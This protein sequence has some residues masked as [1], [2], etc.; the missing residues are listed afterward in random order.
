[1]KLTRERLKKIIKEE[2]QEMASARPIPNMEDLQRDFQG[3]NITKDRY[4]GE[5]KLEGW[6]SSLPRDW[7]KK[8]PKEAHAEFSH[9]GTM[10]IIST[11]LQAGNFGTDEEDSDELKPIDLR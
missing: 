1:M 3:L 2:L 8:L 7:K 6:P 9:D 4:T 10:V 11:G 5:V